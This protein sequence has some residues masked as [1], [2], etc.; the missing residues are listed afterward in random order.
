MPYSQ[1]RTVHPMLRRHTL[2]A[3]LLPAPL[4]AALHTSTGIGTDD[5]GPYLIAVKGGAARAAAS[6]LVGIPGEQPRDL[7]LALITLNGDPHPGGPNRNTAAHTAVARAAAET[8]LDTEYTP[9]GPWHDYAET[10]DITA[11]QV[12]AWSDHGTITVAAT[13]AALN[14]LLH[15]T[16]TCTQPTPRAAARA[17]RF[18]S[19][20][21]W[22]LH[23]GG[24]TDLHDALDDAS[25]FTI[26]LQLA[27]I[28]ETGGD[29]DP[30]LTLLAHHSSRHRYS[31][32]VDAYNTTSYDLWDD[33]WLHPILRPAAA[34]DYIEHAL[35]P[36]D[37]HPGTLLTCAWGTHRAGRAP[38]PQLSDLL[39]NLTPDDVDRYAEGSPEKTVEETILAAGHLWDRWADTNTAERTWGPALHEMLQADAWETSLDNL[40]AQ[41]QPD[42]AGRGRTLR[43]PRRPAAAGRSRST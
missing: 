30:F 42:T 1:A 6:H 39:A 2:P 35:L 19:R 10:R 24:A 12:L 5:D 28:I 11:N 36:E 29:P 16:V 15:R 14:A 4:A 38:G 20:D 22:T 17:L 34:D 27:R 31:T 13:D 33:S 8:G 3:G 32:L 26:A 21:R 7:D 9:E 43:L 23:P 40:P 41:H 25:G 18:A 37:P